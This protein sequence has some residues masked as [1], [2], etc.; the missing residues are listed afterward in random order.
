MATLSDN[1]LV[2]GMQGSLGGR[3]FRSYHGK[4][5]V[6]AKPSIT[7]SRKQSELQQ[8][9][10]SKFG[11]A[12][13]Y[14][15]TM[16]H[17]DA[18]REYYSKKAR[19]MKLPNAYTAAITDYMR[20]IKVEIISTKHYTG[21]AAGGIV[22]V[23]HKKDFTVSEVHVTVTTKSGQEVERGPAIRNTSGEWIYKSTINCAVLEEQ[24]IKVDT[25][26]SHGNI[27]H[28]THQPG[29]KPVCTY[30]WGN[31]LPRTLPLNSQVERHDRS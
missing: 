13:R 31:I 12:S 17:D 23:A 24:I 29:Y 15:K 9:N 14:A 19:K 18:M 22:I 6:S 5:V 2:Q 16:M 10:R 11:D 1:S 21:K 26:D 30:S 7:R 25:K 20:K 3:V 4:T 8:L 27:T 28:A